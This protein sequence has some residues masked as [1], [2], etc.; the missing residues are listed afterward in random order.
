MSRIFVPGVIAALFT[1]SGCSDQ[2]PAPCQ[3]QGSGNGPY[4]MKLTNAG[5]ASANC[6]AVFGDAWLLENYSA[7]LVVMRSVLVD[8]PDPPDGNSTVYGKG[9]FNATDPDA[10]DL[11]TVPSLDAAAPF[12]GPGG[13]TYD[14]TDMAFLSTALYIGTEFKANVT[15]T[16]GA[17]TCNYTAQAINLQVFCTSTSNCDPFIQPTPSGINPLYDQGCNLDQ[18]ATDLALA[19]IGPD[20]YAG[21]GICFF[22]KE[23][24]SLGGFHQ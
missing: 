11:C 5:A 13:S 15:Y 19:Q 7:G 22:N 2:A 10:N 18:W 20:D 9:H 12:D 17:E 3:I 1:L 4:A 24:P 14:V 8:L 16:V 23:F 21:E 6:P